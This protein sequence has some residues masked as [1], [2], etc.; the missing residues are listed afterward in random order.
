MFSF[1]MLAD[2]FPYIWHKRLVADEMI[3]V[4]KPD[5]I[6]VL[7]HL[8][9]ARGENINAGDPLTPEAYYEL[10][11]EQ[12]PRLFRDERLLNG[13]LQDHAIDLT[14]SVSPMDLDGEPSLTMVASRRGDPFRRY[15]LNPAEEVRGVVMI[16]P[17][18]RV[19]RRGKTSVL[20]LSFPS[21]EYADEFQAC[22]RYL[23]D[24]VTVDADLTTVL[25]QTTLGHQYDQLR[26]RGV[27][28][29]LPVGYL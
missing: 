2:A 26:R 3:R 1:V 18:Y 10:F 13:V 29:D 20:T 12:Q 15:D 6:V 7:P 16:N 23:P 24:T 8:H 21:V 9:S 14:G 4:A 11:E 5:S 27:L 22:R 25:S 17:L 19:E 28:L